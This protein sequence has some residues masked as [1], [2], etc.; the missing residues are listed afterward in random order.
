MNQLETVVNRINSRRLE[1]ALDPKDSA[2]IVHFQAYQ[3]DLK[4]PTGW[5]LSEQALQNMQCQLGI[6]A[7]NSDNQCSIVKHGLSTSARVCQNDKD[8]LT[9]IGQILSGQ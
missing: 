5:L 1:A 3:Q 6:A 4:L 9:R 8:C 2:E 7:D